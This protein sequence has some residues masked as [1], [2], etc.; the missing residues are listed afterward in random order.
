MDYS[1]LSISLSLLFFEGGFF[2]FWYTIKPSLKEKRTNFLLSKAKETGQHSKHEDLVLFFEEI[3]GNY[4]DSIFPINTEVTPHKRI[5]VFISLS[6]VL[7]VIYGLL[8]STLDN[9]NI[10]FFSGAVSVSN[11]I[12]AVVLSMW[13]ISVYLGVL[14]LKLIM[15]MDRLFTKE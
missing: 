6:I 8:N 14:E 10:K 12:F 11:I 2:F 13:L 3:I 1:L 9:F 15:K 4:G 7:S 5:V